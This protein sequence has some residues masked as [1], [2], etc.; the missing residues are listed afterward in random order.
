MIDI[1]CSKKFGIEKLEQIGRLVPKICQ[2]EKTLM[3]QVFIWKEIDVKQKNWWIKLRRIDHQQP[4]P[5]KFHY[6]VSFVVYVLMNF[7][8][9]HKLCSTKVFVFTRKGFAL[10]LLSI[11]NPKFSQEISKSAKPAKI[12]HYIT[13]VAYGM[14][15]LALIRQCIPNYYM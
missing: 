13:F 8:Q 5:S 3:N 9:Q 2:T 10:F 15:T 14:S 12:L 11:Y 7:H 6:T 1:L 4:N